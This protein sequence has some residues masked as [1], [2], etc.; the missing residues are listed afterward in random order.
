MEVLTPADAFA[1]QP[2]TRAVADAL[3]NPGVRE[4]LAA[5]VELTKPR[6][7]FLV[8]L[9]AL[10]GYCMGSVG[11]FDYLGFLHLAIGISL[12][13]GGIATL[14]QYLE[15]ESD[16]LMKRTRR[17]PLPTGKLS[18]GSALW[19]GSA[20]SVL[21]TVYLALMVNPL[22]AVW[23]GAAFASYLFL[24]TPLKQ[25]TTLCTFIGAFPGALPPLLGWTAARNEMGVEAFVLFAIL[26]LWQFPHFHA[27]ATMYREDYA[28]AG[29]KMLPVV[30][31][32]YKATAREIVI[33]AAVL[34]PVSLL[35]TLLGMSGKIYLVAAVI[36]G[37]MYLRAGITA[38]RAKTII[39]AR[40]LLKTSVLYLP[41][42]YLMMVLNR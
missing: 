13:S 25:R 4:R 21:A 17:R 27:I 28:Q 16:G 38:A 6:V 1:R 15:R 18:A 24:Y 35:P 42:L 29:I 32:E 37:L 34:L 41:L 31:R 7:T 40:R 36:L 5:Y 19:F 3:P 26:F 8:V 30:D 33:Y 22:T 23:G 12:L 10:A 20:L 9:S 11:S 39:E 14:N 2:A